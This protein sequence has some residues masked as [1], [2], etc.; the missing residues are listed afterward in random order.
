MKKD[1]TLEAYLYRMGLWALVIGIPVIL[2]YFLVWN[3]YIHIPCFMDAFFHIY[4]LGCG[5]T[6]AF[7]ALLRGDLLAS[8]WYHPLVP[9]STV[10]YLGYMGSHSLERLHVPKVK[11]WKFHSWYLY[12]ALVLLIANFV[13][14][15]IARCVWD[16][17][18]I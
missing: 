12:T 14:K 18:M 5:G 8:V 3:R 7:A 15:N 17:H 13:I 16:I 4:C 2:L 6:R 11:G 1:S 9:Y 10:M